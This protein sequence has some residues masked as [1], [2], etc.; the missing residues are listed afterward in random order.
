MDTD[1]FRGRTIGRLR[2][3]AVNTNHRERPQKKATLHKCGSQTS[4]FQNCKKIDVSPWHFVTAVP[5]GWHTTLTCSTP[6]ASLAE[7]IFVHLDTNITHLKSILP[8][9]LKPNQPWSLLNLFVSCSI[10]NIFYSHCLGPNSMLTH[11]TYSMVTGFQRSY[12][13]TQASTSSK[14]VLPE[15]QFMHVTSFH[16]LLEFHVLTILCFQGVSA[17]KR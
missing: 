1:I 4:S 8:P 13:S 7:F 5:T 17:L 10:I 14:F 2:E 16:L 6:P 11:N 15:N 9:F 3:K 12:F